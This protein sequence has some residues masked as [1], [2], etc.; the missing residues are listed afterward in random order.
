VSKDKITGPISFKERI[1]SE[2][3]V[4]QILTHDKHHYAFFHNDSPTSHTARA[5]MCAEQHRAFPVYAVIWL[6]YISYFFR[7]EGC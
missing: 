5:G 6:S 4:E 3:C 2:R 7:L 1:N